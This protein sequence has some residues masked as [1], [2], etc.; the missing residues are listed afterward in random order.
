MS[1]LEVVDRRRV[2]FEGEN[3]EPASSRKLGGLTPAFDRV[4]IKV[5][6]KENTG[7]IVSPDAFDEPSLYGEVIA[8]G[9]GVYMGGS[10]YPIPFQVGDIV[11]YTLVSFESLTDK[12]SD[13]EPGQYGFVRAQD[14]R[15]Y[16][17]G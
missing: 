5:L 15:C 13:A 17:H 16:W 1:D 12:F 14:I 8:V 3:I 2:N 11:R 4:L 9:S 6:P 7:T 10:V